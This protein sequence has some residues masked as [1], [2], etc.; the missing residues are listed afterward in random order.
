MAVAPLVPR[1][2]AEEV[3]QSPDDGLRYEVVR[4]ELLVAPAPGTAHQR[5]VRDI[6]RRLQDYLETHD[7]GEALP[8]P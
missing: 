6:C 8:A 3:R 1:Y 4:G 5:A 7:I 2:S